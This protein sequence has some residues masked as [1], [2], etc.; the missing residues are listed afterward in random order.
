MIKLVVETM[1]ACTN[2]N[3]ELNLCGSDEAVVHRI[4]PKDHR[5]GMQTNYGGQNTC[6]QATDV[7]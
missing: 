4:G 7:E 3:N 5:N 2:F 6:E 1:I